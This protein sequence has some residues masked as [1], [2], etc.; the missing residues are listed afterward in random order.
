VSLRC[1]SLTPYSYRVV[2]RLGLLV[3]FTTCHRGKGHSSDP[4]SVALTALQCSHAAA[5]LFYFCEEKMRAHEGERDAWMPRIPA[6][7]SSARISFA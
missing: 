5:A 2:I 6:S 3:G 1:A 7:A 4:S